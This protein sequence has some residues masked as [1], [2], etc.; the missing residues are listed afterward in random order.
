MELSRPYV[1]E[2]KFQSENLKGRSTGRPRCRW[3]DIDVKR[4]ACDQD[5]IHLA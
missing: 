3:G 2:T 4:M 1:Y 5:R